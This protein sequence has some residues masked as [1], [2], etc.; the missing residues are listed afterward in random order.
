MAVNYR[1][2]QASA[3]CGCRSRTSAGRTWRLQDQ[4]GAAVYDRDG[5][6]LQARG[7]F[8]DVPP[9]Q[10]LVFSLTPGA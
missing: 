8:L 4:L 6:D 3:T 2:H 1:R 5:N 10:A 9:W 7:L